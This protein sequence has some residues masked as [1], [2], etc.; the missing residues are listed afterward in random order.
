MN[1]RSVRYTPVLVRFDIVGGER[2]EK[3]TKEGDTGRVGQVETLAV[4]AKVLGATHEPSHGLKY[5]ESL[6]RHLVPGALQPV[7]GRRAER[8][9]DGRERRVVVQRA[10]FLRLLARESI[11]VKLNLHRPLQQSA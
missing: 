3:L 7:D 8:R 2:G 1:V 4:L 5:G 11:K 9:Y 10:A 6:R